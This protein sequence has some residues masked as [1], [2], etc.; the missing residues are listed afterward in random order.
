[1][2]CEIKTDTSNKRGNWNYLKIIQANLSNV[3][4]KDEISC[5][6]HCTHTSESTDVIVNTYCMCEITLHVTQIVSKE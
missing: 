4:K 2:A 3:P 5:I 1:V 6:G